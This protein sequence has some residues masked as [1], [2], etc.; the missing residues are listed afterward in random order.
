M[1]EKDI[2]RLTKD[3]LIDLFK[4]LYDKYQPMVIQEKPQYQAECLEQVYRAVA[5]ALV[6]I[7]RQGTTFTIREE[8]PHVRDDSGSL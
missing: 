8:P 5:D 6:G 2:E 3:E 1:V 4:F 7:I